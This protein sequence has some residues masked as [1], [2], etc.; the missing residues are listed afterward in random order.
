M[1]KRSRDSKSFWNIFFM[2]TLANSWPWQFS[3]FHKSTHLSMGL[4]ALFT[5]VVILLALRVQDYGGID[6]IDNRRMNK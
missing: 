5:N 6:I 2:F 1:K 3:I 4:T